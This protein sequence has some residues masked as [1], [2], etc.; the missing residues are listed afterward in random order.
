MNGNERNAVWNEAIAYEKSTQ[1]AELFEN[2]EK[3]DV[4]R[5]LF[6]KAYEQAEAETD[7]VKKAVLHAYSEGFRH[8]INILTT[9]GNGLNAYRNITNP[10]IKIELTEEDVRKYRGGA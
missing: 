1:L 8:T 3:Y 5:A 7:P 10:S 4:V 9:R 2:H 6:A